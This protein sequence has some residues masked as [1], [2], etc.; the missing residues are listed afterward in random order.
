MVALTWRTHVTAL[1]GWTVGVA[2][3]GT[4]MGAITP[5]VSDL[6][7]TEAGHRMIEALGGTGALE[8]AL[9]AA[10]LSIAAVAITCFGITVVVHGSADEYEGRTEQ[11]LATATSRTR[12]FAAALL[13]ALAGTLWL[14]TVTG[15]AAGLGLGRD[16]PDL[17]AA[18]LAQVPA[19]WLVTT[20][21]ALLYAARSTWAVLAW[22]LLGLFLVLGQLG[23]LLELPRWLVAVSPYDHTPAM[24]ARPFRALPP[25]VLTGLA[26]MVSVVAWLGYRRRDIG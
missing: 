17:V 4:V 9:L 8:D 7:D 2:A 14:L 3:L 24:P 25:L 23:D 15:L 19:V 22:G 1:V 12:A 26:G 6:L 13:V 20:L 5:G 10:I 11:V 18:A 16:V 21:A